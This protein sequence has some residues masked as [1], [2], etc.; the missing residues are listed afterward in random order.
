MGEVVPVLHNPRQPHEVS[1][2]TAN[3]MRSSS[4]ERGGVDSIAKRLQQAASNDYQLTTTAATKKNSLAK[5]TPQISSIA[6][7]VKVKKLREAKKTIS[8]S[9]DSLS[10]Y[11]ESLEVVTP[12]RASL[13]AHP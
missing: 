9:S 1:N 8:V 2:L 3:S 10:K 11:N 12:K 5:G 7:G 6:V 4:N 13:A